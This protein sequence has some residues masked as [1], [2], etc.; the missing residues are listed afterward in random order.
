MPRGSKPGERRG[1]RQR[2]TPN[3]KTAL[4]NAAISAAT[5]D[6]STSPLDFLLR[7]M[8]DP[9]LTLDLRVDLATAAAPFVHGKPQRLGQA[10]PECGDPSSEIN[11]EGA[12]SGTAIE[13]TNSGAGK[14][15]N[16]ST[17]M[18]RA[19]LGTEIEL[20][21]G[22]AKEGMNSSPEKGE[23]T[24]AG[25]GEPSEASDGRGALDPIVPVVEAPPIVPASESAAD[26]SPLDFLLSVM[27]D[28]Q[29]APQPRHGPPLSASMNWTPAP[30]SVRRMAY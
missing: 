12:N 22:T 21:S 30:S 2:G 4:R 16:S 6:P 9:N 10:G 14:G 26:L 3:K 25:V 5:A 23:A 15:V 28:P 27:K 19:D 8:R 11:G 29:A 13:G 24:L 1:G 18:Q 17:E 20:D 7:L